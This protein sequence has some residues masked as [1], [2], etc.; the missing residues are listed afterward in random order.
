MNGISWHT[1][2]AWTTFTA[3][4]TSS[5]I[6]AALAVLGLMYNQTSDVD[7]MATLDGVHFDID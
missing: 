2:L 5:I 6:V 4:I 1:G 3:G 7:E